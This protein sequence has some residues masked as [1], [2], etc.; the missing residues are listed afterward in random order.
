MFV[1]QAKIK[2]TFKT[3]IVIF[4]FKSINVDKNLT[5]AIQANFPHHFS[6]TNKYQITELSQ[7]T[8]FFEEMRLSSS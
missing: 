4:N 6:F 1:G 3:K 7:L 2:V 5:E 8:E